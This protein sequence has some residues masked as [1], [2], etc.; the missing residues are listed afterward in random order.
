[1]PA[2][3]EDF[4][5]ASAGTAPIAG[6]ATTTIEDITASGA[7]VAVVIGTTSTTL[8]DATVIGVGSTSAASVTGA[9]SVV[10]EDF[11]GTGAGGVHVAGAAA[12]TLEDVTASGAGGA[13]HLRDKLKTRGLRN[14]RDGYHRG[15]T[16]QTPGA[17]S[18]A[19]A[20]RI[21]TLPQNL[22]ARSSYL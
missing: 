1:M 17:V 7:G 8:E 13:P 15:T 19:A 9:A 18:R 21:S 4:T 22:P 11:T 16:G 6:A 2:S 20:S 14:G 10:L 3:L 12:S 5:G